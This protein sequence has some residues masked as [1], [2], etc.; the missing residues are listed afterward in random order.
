[1]S[2]PATDQMSAMAIQVRTWAT[3]CRCLAASERTRASSSVDA[4]SMRS[5]SGGHTS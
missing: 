3:A 1:M 4:S 5:V 2:T